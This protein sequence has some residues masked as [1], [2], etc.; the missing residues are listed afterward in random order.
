M[1]HRAR[2]PASF[3]DEAALNA[4]HVRNRCPTRAVD[5]KTPYEV[6]TGRKPSIEG[7][8]VFGTLA[9]VHV[10]D[11]TRRTGKLSGR[12]FPCVFL[13]YSTEAKAWRLYNPAS[14]TPKKR[15]VISRD[16]T[17]LEDRLVDIDGILA[18]TRIGE[19]EKGDAGSWFPDDDDAS[20]VSESKDD[21][22][23]PDLIPPSADLDIFN[24]D[25]GD[26]ADDIDEDGYDFL[27][28]LPFRH[29]FPAELASSSPAQQALYA[30][31]LIQH[32]QVQALEEQMWALSTTVLDTD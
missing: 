27:D 30:I 12:G 9:Y 23:L 5:G 20:S 4:V 10:D 24:L 2:L 16:V 31:Q 1:L 15:L 7:F 6:W 18:S 28:S 32:Q 8:R 13:G 26:D 21:D 3:W 19:G 22:G 29:L 17:F 25:V 14:K 11:A